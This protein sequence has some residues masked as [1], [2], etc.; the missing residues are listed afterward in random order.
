MHGSR[1]AILNLESR[2]PFI[3]QLGLVGPVPIGIFNLRGAAF[4]DLGMAWNAGESPRVSHIDADG[5]RR[6]QDLLLG[7]GVGARTAVSFLL[8][9]LDV[10]WHSDFH[11]V[12]QPRW[13]FSIGPEF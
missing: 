9:K 10:G 3:Q 13:H 5:N 6:L 1:V 8:L 4:T 12:S 7:F 11:D 2:F